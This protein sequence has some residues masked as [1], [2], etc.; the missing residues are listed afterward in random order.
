MATGN[1]KNKKTSGIHFYDKEGPI[2]ST[3]Q[4]CR[5]HYL[6]A[7]QGEN[8]EIQNAVFSKQ[9]TPQD[10]KL[11]LYFKVIFNLG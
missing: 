9:K 6:G 1:E 3:R 7:T 11:V 4:F 8:S 2:F 5:G 10:A